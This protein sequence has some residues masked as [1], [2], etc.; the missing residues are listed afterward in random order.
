MRTSLKFFSGVL[1]FVF[2][3][4]TSFANDND[5]TITLKVPGD[6]SIKPMQTILVSLDP[7]PVSGES[8]FK[9]YDVSCV[10]KNNSFQDKNPVY[11]NFG[12]GGVSS[13]WFIYLN[14]VQIGSSAPLSKEKAL[15]DYKSVRVA[16]TQKGGYLSF[17]N[18]DQ[19][20]TVVITKCSALPN[21]SIQ[22]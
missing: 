14:D 12:F 16:I 2:M 21:T 19:D 22:D 10:I 15:N 6:G 7:L 3:V 4:S 13:L 18:Q 17:M 8:S 9:P 11:M 1:F 20:H 5:S